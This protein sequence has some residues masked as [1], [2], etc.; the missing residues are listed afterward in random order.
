MGRSP[1]KKMA[2]RVA[3]NNWEEGQS[4]WVVWISMIMCV[5]I[6]DIWCV[7]FI[8]KGNM[9]VVKRV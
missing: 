1:R 6:K 7:Y 3:E 5:C 9:H 8:M 2:E 4:C